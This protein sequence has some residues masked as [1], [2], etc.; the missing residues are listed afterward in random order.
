MRACFADDGVVVVFGCFVV[1]GEVH[2]IFRAVRPEW[3]ARAFWVLARRNLDVLGRLRSGLPAVLEGDRG[4]VGDVFRVRMDLFLVQTVDVD[5]GRSLNVVVH[6]WRRQPLP[7][8]SEACVRIGG[9]RRRRPGHAL[10]DHVM[11]QAHVPGRRQCRWETVRN[12]RQTATER[13]VQFGVREFVERV[14]VR[15]LQRLASR[16]SPKTDDITV[17]ALKI[18]RTRVR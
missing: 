18:T 15:A 5:G 9:R 2:P 12:A 16:I 4:R 14:N 11:R 10:R 3:R 17:N 6:R 13:R 8:S 7:L 1:H